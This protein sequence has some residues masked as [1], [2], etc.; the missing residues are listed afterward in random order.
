MK[1][2]I[3]IPDAVYESA[4]KLARRLGESRSELYT[5][6]VKSYIERQQDNKVTEKLNEVY[7]TETSKLDPVLEN[8]QVQSWVKNNPW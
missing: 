8:L 6:A 7:R 2:A 3:S 1:T 4:E 5:K